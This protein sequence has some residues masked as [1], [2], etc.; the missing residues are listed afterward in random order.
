MKKTFLNQIIVLVMVLFLSTLLFSCEGDEPIPTV[1]EVKYNVIF[2]VNAGDDQVNNEPDVVRI[3]SGAVVTQPSPNPSRNGF[4]FAGWY[5]TSATDGAQYVFSTPVTANLVLY[6]KWTITIQYFTVSLDFSG[7]GINSTQQIAEGDTVDE[8]AEPVRVGYRF[9]GWYI[10]QAFSSQYNFTNTVDDDFTIFAKWVQL[11]T[12]TF[13]QNYQDAP[14]A[15]QQILDINETAVTPESP[16]RSAYTFG[17]WFMDAEGTTPYEFP[18]VV[19]NITV[20]AKW[21]ENSTAIAY[22]VELDYNYDGS[23]D[24]IIQTITEGGVISQPNTTRQNYRFL[25][26]YL[27]QGTYLNRFSSSTPVTSDLMLYAN[28]VHTYQLSINYNYSGSINPSGL[29]VDEGIAITVPQSPSRIGFTFAGW[30]DNS[31]GIIGF[32][33]SEGIFENTAVYAQWSKTNVFEA[34]YLDFSDFFGWGF[35]GNATGTDAIVEDAT[36]VGQAS[37]GRFVTYLYGKGITLLYEIYSDRNVSNVTLT[38]RLSGEVMDFYIQS[39]KTIG[40]LEEEPVYTVKVNDVALQYAN[41]SFTDVPS[42]SEN[43]LLPF[44]DFIISVNVNLVEGKN[45]I[46]LITDNAL[47]MGGTMGATAPMVDCIKINTYAILTWNP[48]LDNY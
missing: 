42:Q 36:G 15:T 30:S 7:G 23:P 28:W 39:T 44:T 33:F 16:V 1:V 25:G 3:T 20:Y 13:N 32:D 47:L 2:D 10:D 24:N 41:I 29:V 40:V 38:L 4:D 35:S 12:V 5:L 22:T 46:A 19:E 27:D 45:T 17:G 26:W 18:A 34:E 14:S 8:P 48:I 21:I 37:N 11:V 43:T 9:A 6:A 31:I